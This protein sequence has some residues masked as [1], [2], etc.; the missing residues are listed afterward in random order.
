MAPIWDNWIA[1]GE[2]I[3][4]SRAKMVDDLYYIFRHMHIESPFHGYVPAP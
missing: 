4:L 1:E 2:E 3:G